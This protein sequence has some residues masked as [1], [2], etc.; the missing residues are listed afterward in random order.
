MNI[1]TARGINFPFFLNPVKGDQISLP[2]MKVF[3]D[4]IEQDWTT[5]EKGKTNRSIHGDGHDRLAL[6]AFDIKV[7]AS[8]VQKLLLSEVRINGEI[9]NFLGCSSN[10]L[11]NRKCFMWKGG[12]GGVT[13]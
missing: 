2:T 11:K 10:G 1:D 5:E 9:Y 4:Y 3:Q 6:L 12:G 13:K 7:G 8:D